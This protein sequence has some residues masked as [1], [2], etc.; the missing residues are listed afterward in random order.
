MHLWI[1]VLQWRLRLKLKWEMTLLFSTTQVGA[2]SDLLAYIIIYPTCKSYLV[3]SGIMQLNT[4][5]IG[6]IYA[7]FV[8]VRAISAKC[9]SRISVRTTIC[10]FQCVREGL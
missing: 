8:C 10:L 7:S 6:A 1:E 9:E 3:D 5:S 4:P 2:W